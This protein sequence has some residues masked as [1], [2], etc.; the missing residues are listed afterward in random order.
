MTDQGKKAIQALKTARGQIDGIIKMIEDDRY[1]IDISNQIIAAGAQIKRANMI[2]LENHMNC[3]VK[4]AFLHE[5][6]E[7]KVKELMQVLEKLLYK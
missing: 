6:G 2:I 7:E 5:S 3:C 4:E 1:C